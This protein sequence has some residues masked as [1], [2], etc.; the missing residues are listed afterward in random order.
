MVANLM[1]IKSPYNVN[2]SA[3]IAGIASLKDWRFR[4]L[5]VSKVKKGRE[6]LER[7][8][9]KNK[10]LKLVN[11]Q[12]NF[13]FLVISRELGQKIKYLCMKEGMSFR[14]FEI[15][16]KYQAIRITI[17]NNKQNRVVLNIFKNL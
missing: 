13:I 3:V 1:K 8:L 12:G 16:D 11:S 5:T 4:E 15:D 17:G 9:G 6:M 2:Y 7:E 10:K 14:F